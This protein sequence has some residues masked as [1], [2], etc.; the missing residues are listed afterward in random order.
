MATDQDDM[1]WQ[2]F[3]EGMVC[4]Q[5]QNIQDTY[6][7]VE[8]SNIL[9]CQWSQ[10]LVVKLLET[11][12]GQWLY[13]CVQVHDKVAGTCINACKEEIHCEIERQLEL[14]CDFFAPIHQYTNTQKTVFLMCKGFFLRNRILCIC[15]AKKVI[16]LDRYMNTH[17]T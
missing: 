9:S 10:G 11:T 15:V 17:T 14:G 1:G 3:M 16:C 4:R 6:S 13:R 7:S 12:H 2:R 5:A 8:G